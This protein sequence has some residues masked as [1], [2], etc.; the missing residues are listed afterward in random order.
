MDRVPQVDLRP[1]IEELDAEIIGALRSVLR[2]G[3]FILGPEVGAFEEQVASYCAV[4]HAIGVASGSDALELILRALD[5][6]SDDEV[7][8]PAFTFIATATSVVLA[9]ARPVFVDVT[10]D[11]LNLDPGLLEEAITSKTKAIIAVDLYG[12]PAEMDT[13]VGI[14]RDRG[15][16][17][18][19]DAAQSLGARLGEV[20]AGALADSAAL[21]FFPSKNLGAF[22]DAGMVLTDDSELA[23]RAQMLR[24]HGSREKYWHETLGRNSRLDTLQAAILGVKLKNLDRWVEARRS[25]AA[26]YVSAL[27]DVRGVEVPVERPG[28]SHSYHQFTVQLDHRDEVRDGMSSRG[29][30]TAVHYPHAI[31]DQP[32]FATEGDWPVSRR[33]AARVLSLP[34]FPELTIAQRERVVEALEA[35]IV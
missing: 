14:A 2:S 16:H 6:G 8:V 30:D 1:H 22:G 26:E 20:R 13:I 3:R 21:S 18:V 29:V 31:P 10:Q 23:E 9:G 28:A 32:C 17:V 5:V 7:I 15:I 34:M 33:A 4:S 25:H 35:S 19:E 11:T 27:S 24:A 12:H